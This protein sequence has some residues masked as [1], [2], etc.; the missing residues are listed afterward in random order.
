MNRYAFRRA[1]LADAPLLA[2]WRAAPHVAAWWSQETRL[3]AAWF[4][5]PEVRRWIV[6]LEGRDFAFI[7]DYSVHA[8]PGH[9]FAH[10]P[11]GS[12]GID[13]F[14]GDPEMLGQ[15]HGPGFI[16]A[17]AQRLFAEGAPVVATDPHPDNGRAIA[18]CRNAGFAV[19]GPP[20]DTP[21]G[22]ILPMT[23]GRATP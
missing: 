1:A 9:H 6:G 22:P 19:S 4:A 10:L 11:P 17:H 15:G 12:R 2:A 18:A 8:E 7:Q 13:Q 5:A 23:K 21:W 3:D 16:A 14:I 20:R